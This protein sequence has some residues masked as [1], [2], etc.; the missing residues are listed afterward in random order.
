MK[1]TFLITVLLFLS[2][3]ELSAQANFQIKT[4]LAQANMIWENPDDNQRSKSGFLL[5]FAAN[6]EFKEYLGLQT[7]LLF[8]QQGF[9]IKRDK[10]DFIAFNYNYLQIPLLLRGQTTLGPVKAFF[11]TGPSL[12]L[13]LGGREYFETQGN[14]FGFPVSASG[15]RQVKFKEGQTNSETVYLDP[16]RYNRLDLAI[17][18]G[19][20]VEYKLGPGALVFE[21]R[22]GFGRNNFRKETSNTIG[23]VT[24]TQEGDGRSSVTAISLG[25]QFSLGN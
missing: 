9:Q 10:N 22:Q 20:G 6:Y 1:N 2:T 23:N 16:E 3:Y 8:Q 18:I 17:Q 7:E 21:Y 15:E 25:Y 5:G 12:G 11:H 4:G 24:I 13:A 19:F 14:F